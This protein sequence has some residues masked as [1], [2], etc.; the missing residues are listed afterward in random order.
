MTRPLPEAAD[1]NPAFASTTN[2]AGSAFNCW[3]PGGQAFTDP[4]DNPGNPG[5]PTSNQ[6]AHLTGSYAYNAYLL[7]DTPSGD[8]TVLYGS[9]GANNARNA[10]WLYVPPVP[11]SSEVP[12]ICDGVWSTAWPKEADNITGVPSLYAPAGTGTM[13][14]GNNWTRICIARHGMAINVGFMDGHAT[15][16][17]LPDLWTLKWHK[18]WNLANL[19]TPNDL[20]TVRN[21]IKNMY[22]G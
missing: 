16:V 9:K 21:T 14:I 3:G 6:G 18:G 2:Q 11:S 1:P 15:T 22:K 17:Q 7:R 20:T 4:N 12:A 8:N 13:N 10:S 19:P 5:N